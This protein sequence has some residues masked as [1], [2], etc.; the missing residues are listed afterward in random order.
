MPAVRPALAELRARI[1]EIDGTGSRQHGVLPFGVRELDRR[2]PQ[3]GLSRGALHEVAG[4]GN[5]AVDGAA[6]ACFVAGIAA[7]TQGKVLW[8][9]AQQ[10]LFAPG[11][12]QAGLPPDRVIHVEAGDDK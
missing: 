4:G 10:D 3:G 5:G 1:G 9:V 7:R 6:A 12:E 11:L 8:C 2:L